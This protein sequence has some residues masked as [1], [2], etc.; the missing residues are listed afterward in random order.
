MLQWHVGMRLKAAESSKDD[1]TEPLLHCGRHKVASLPVIEKQ[2]YLKL[3]SGA[4]G[5]GRR[6]FIILLLSR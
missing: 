1:I 5:V 2:C 6:C 4:R 3:I